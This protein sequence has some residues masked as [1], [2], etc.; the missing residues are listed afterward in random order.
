MQELFD[1]IKVAEGTRKNMGAE[2][3]TEV[4]EIPKRR[5]LTNQFSE[6]FGDLLAL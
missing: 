2:M 6:A 1:K 3:A 5:K 4:D